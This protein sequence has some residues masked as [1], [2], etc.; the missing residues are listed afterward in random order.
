M[1]YLNNANIKCIV[2]SSKNSR[3]IKEQE[4]SGLFSNLGNKTRLRKILPLGNILFPIQF[5]ND[6]VVVMKILI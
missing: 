5:H 6:L 2:C 4:E 3:F 1:K